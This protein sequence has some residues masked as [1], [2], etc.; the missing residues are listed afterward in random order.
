MRFMDRIYKLDIE[1]K[2]V[3]LNICEMFKSTRVPTY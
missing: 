3:S 1:F 2:N